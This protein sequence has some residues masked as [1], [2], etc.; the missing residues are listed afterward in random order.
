MYFHCISFIFLLFIKPL[1]MLNTSHSFIELANAKVLVSKQQKIIQQEISD[2]Q[3]EISWNLNLP[4]SSQLLHLSILTRMNQNEI[5]LASRG[6]TTK[7]MIMHGDDL[8]PQFQNR[9]TPIENGIIINQLIFEVDH[10][11]SFYASVI[12][13]HKN[14]TWREKSE[15]VT[16]LQ[17]DPPEFINFSPKSN[18]L[19]NAEG[20]VVC[21]VRSFPEIMNIK[22][23]LEGIPFP[24]N[25]EYPIMT[26]DLKLKYGIMSD[27]RLFYSIA[28]LRY[29]NMRHLLLIV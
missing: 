12:Y 29:N 7:T 25:K 19:E 2:R 4:S 3:I 14:H 6:S 5:Y 15:E 23:E 28:I 18:I 11:R 17:K 8:P 1:G 20:V 9:I 24:N 27:S 22:W 10:S 26:K 13:I 21:L 16:L